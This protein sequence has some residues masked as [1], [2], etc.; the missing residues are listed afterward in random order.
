MHKTAASLTAPT[1]IEC[2]VAAPVVLEDVEEEEVAVV[3][4]SELVVARGARAVGA[5]A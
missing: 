4:L 5:M 3:V 1:A 2:V